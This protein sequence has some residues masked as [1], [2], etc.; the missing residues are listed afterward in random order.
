MQHVA[1][2][3]VVCSAMLHGVSGRRAAR[4][5]AQFG[6]SR[7]VVEHWRGWWRRLPL[8]A[9][10]KHVRGRLPVAFDGRGLPHSLLDVFGGEARERLVALLRFLSPVTSR[11][12]PGRLA[13]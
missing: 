9:F 8:G 11:S 12:A 13:I 5:R 1:A 2:V 4:I 3:M 6:V 10:W 7:A